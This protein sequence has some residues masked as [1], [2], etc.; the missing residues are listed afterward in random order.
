VAQLMRQG[1]R[2]VL[3]LRTVRIVDQM[4]QGGR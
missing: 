1:H 2:L 4:N 3:A